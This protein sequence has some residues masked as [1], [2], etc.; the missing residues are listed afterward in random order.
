MSIADFQKT[1]SAAE[2]FDV[3]LTLDT[4]AYTAGD[5]LSDTATLSNA[6]RMAGGRMQLVS[7]SVTDE[8]DQG[9]AFDIYFFDTNVSLGTK[10]SAPNISDANARTT[11]GRVPIAT[12]D[13]A[14]LGGVRIANVRNIGLLLEAAA[15]SRD[16][17]IGTVNGAGTPT[18]TVNGLKLRLGFL[19]Y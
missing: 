6:F 2:F 3:T 4:S 14:D 13:Y 18:F 15:G 10:N 11:I 19:Q 17:F 5:V 7:L 12:T 8:D 16:L 1:V 9:V